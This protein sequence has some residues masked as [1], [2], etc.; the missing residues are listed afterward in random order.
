VGAGFPIF[1]GGRKGEALIQ[2]IFKTMGHYRHKHIQVYAR[3]WASLSR[4]RFAC[5]LGGES[6]VVIWAQR[7]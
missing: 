1:E 4:K 5:A 2:R 7:A 3:K 6:W